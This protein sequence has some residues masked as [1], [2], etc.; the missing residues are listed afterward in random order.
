MLV[1]VIGELCKV[2]FLLLPL[3]S[4]SEPG[5]HQPWETSTFYQLSH[6][7]WLCL[8]LYAHSGV[9]IWKDLIFSNSQLIIS[10]L[11]VSPYVTKC[12]N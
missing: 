4:G 10:V 9:K 12:D 1:A 11:F 8:T 5:H 7:C 2:S 6:L 3:T